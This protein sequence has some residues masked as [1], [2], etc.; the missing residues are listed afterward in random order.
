MCIGGVRSQPVPEPAHT[1]WQAS[2]A[3][4]LTEDR[5]RPSHRATLFRSAGRKD[6]HRN[7]HSRHAAQR[8]VIQL[9]VYGYTMTA[10]VKR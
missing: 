2:T 7:S 10:T 3:S 9:A 5:Q 6:T 8:G 1:I 4:T